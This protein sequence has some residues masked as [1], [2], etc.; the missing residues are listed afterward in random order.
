MMTL[1][2]KQLLYWIPLVFSSVQLEDDVRYNLPRSQFVDDRHKS[3]AV[4]RRKAG[5]FS[6]IMTSIPENG[7]KQAH[8]QDH[9]QRQHCTTNPSRTNT[10][11]SA[12]L[13]CSPA[14]P[15]RYNNVLASKSNRCAESVHLKV[16][17]VIKSRGKHEELEETGHRKQCQHRAPFLPKRSAVSHFRQ[18]Q[19]AIF[20]QSGTFLLSDDA[21]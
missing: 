10:K 16:G 21:A 14:T 20:P 17:A 6:T 11:V 15:I 19:R 9:Q 12:I 8:K 3:A 7:S 1:W 2:K 18:Q 5:F 4:F 13:Y